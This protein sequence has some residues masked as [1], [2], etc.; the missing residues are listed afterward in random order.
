MMPKKCSVCLD[1][2][3]AE[4]IDER[5]RAGEPQSEIALSTGFSADVIFRHA[6]HA[7]AAQPKPL[8]QLRALAG[9]IEKLLD[10]AALSGDVRTASESAAQL[11][12]LWDRIHDADSREQS[13]TESAF[14]NLSRERQLDWI[15]AHGFAMGVFD[16][17]NAEC[18]AMGRELGPG[19]CPS[20]LRPYETS[21]PENQ[22]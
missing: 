17:V 1:P 7:T 20:C 5:L 16:R 19:H 10:A 4:Q 11:A 9:K 13:Q 18:T 12:R 6:R 15:M 2:V 8:D 14:E 3:T 21:A 22:N